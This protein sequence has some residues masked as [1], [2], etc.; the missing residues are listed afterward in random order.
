MTR[1]PL[2]PSSLL[3]NTNNHCSIIC[4]VVSELSASVH[5]LT[6]MHAIHCHFGESS[7]LESRVI[8]KT[9]PPE[10]PLKIAPQHGVQVAAFRPFKTWKRRC[11]AQWDNLRLQ[12]T[13]SRLYMSARSAPG[14]YSTTQQS[15]TGPSMLTVPAVVAS[16]G[17]KHRRV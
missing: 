16:F 3:T 8:F 11:G 2:P 6:N 4:E 5:K 1:L 10:E 13:S 15:H 14:V 9:H 17:Q 12:A 7:K